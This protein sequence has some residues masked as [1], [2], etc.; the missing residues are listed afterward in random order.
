MTENEAEEL[1]LSF[2][3]VTPQ[4]VTLGAGTGSARTI[5]LEPPTS[6]TP[7]GPTGILIDRRQGTGDESHRE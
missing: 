7:S 6:P 2:A 1:V 5:S 3:T 4:R